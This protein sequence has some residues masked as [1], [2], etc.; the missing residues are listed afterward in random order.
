MNW[1]IARPAAASPRAM[2]RP[3]ASMTSCGASTNILCNR[4]ERTPL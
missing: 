2:Y 3:T 1:S 4:S